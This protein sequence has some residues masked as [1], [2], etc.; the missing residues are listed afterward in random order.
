MAATYSNF[1]LD[2][3]TVEAY[4][5]QFDYVTLPVGYCA[6][7]KPTDRKALSVATTAVDRR[8]LMPTS[9]GF[10]LR[11]PA[12]AF[13]LRQARVSRKLVLLND[14]SGPLPR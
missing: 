9:Q 2:K 10:T 8:A 11:Q 14:R 13:D 12:R 5:I 7:E 6:C 1:A 3:A 4:P